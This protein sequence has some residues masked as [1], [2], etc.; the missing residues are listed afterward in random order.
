MVRK[1]AGDWA[2]KDD[3]QVLSRTLEEKIDGV[4]TELKS[5]V[6]Q[7]QTDLS[8]LKEQYRSLDGR[9]CGLAVEVVKTRDRIDEV[10]ISLKQEMRD[11]RADMTSRM[12]AFLVRFETIWRESAVFPVI[13]DEHGT[14][15]RGHE[16]R[17]WALEV[18][19]DG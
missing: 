10:E 1:Q 4:R 9:I 19:P 13:L 7:L 15:L 17:I 6:A 14:T 3:L 16:T 12:D 18:R 2:T 8:Q 11:L 5:D